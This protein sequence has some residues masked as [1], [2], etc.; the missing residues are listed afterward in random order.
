MNSIPAAP[1]EKYLTVRLLYLEKGKAFDENVVKAAINQEWSERGGD[2]SQLLD[3]AASPEIIPENPARA[4]AIRLD[5]RAAK[6]ELERE[7]LAGRQ[8]LAARDAAARETAL[9][10]A[11][12]AELERRLAALGGDTAA[13]SAPAPETKG[14]DE[15]APAPERAPE[16]VPDGTWR[17]AEIVTW[18]EQ[19]GYT[20]P[21]NPTF[22]STAVVLDHVLTQHR[23]TEEGAEA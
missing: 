21:P 2:A 20:L 1:F 17:K 11:R 6:Q 16:A 19:H 15:A 23:L 4:R 10:D 14:G 9:K 12:I 5:D 7:A 18:A 22:A 13:P 3:L 8:R